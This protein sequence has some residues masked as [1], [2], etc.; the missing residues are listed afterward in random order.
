MASGGRTIARCAALPTTL[1]NRSAEKRQRRRLTVA[2]QLDERDDDAEDDAGIAGGYASNALVDPAAPYNE[3]VTVN[4]VG[5][6]PE[7]RRSVQP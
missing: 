7:T 2:R 1:D 3:I 5:D 4:G 6:L